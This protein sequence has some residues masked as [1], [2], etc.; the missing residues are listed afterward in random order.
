MSV[1]QPALATITVSGQTVQY[2]MQ[3]SVGHVAPEL[4]DAMHLGPGLAPDYS[5]LLRAVEEKIHVRSDGRP[6]EAAPAH[7]M[8]P[9]QGGASALVM[10]HFACAD[11]PK[12]LTVRDDLFEVLG[13]D[14]HTIANIQWAGEPAVRLPARSARG[15]RD[16][17]HGRDN[18]RRG[19]LLP[20]SASSTS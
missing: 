4:A 17:V 5:P 7:L 18:Q 19:Q 12:E 9:A 2:N 14:Y 20:C 16:R 6:C 11:P 8:P 15:A 3:L 1:A 13:S 10:L